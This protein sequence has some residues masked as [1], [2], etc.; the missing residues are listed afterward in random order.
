MVKIGLSPA[1]YNPNDEESAL[2]L[3]PLSPAY[4]TKFSDLIYP[5][6]YNSGTLLS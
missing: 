2:N 5:C 6:T 1:S 3:F 4:A